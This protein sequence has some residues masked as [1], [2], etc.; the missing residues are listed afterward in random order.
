MFVVALLTHLAALLSDLL[1]ELA[2]K[3]SLM[4]EAWLLLG[5]CPMSNQK[6]TNSRKRKPMTLDEYALVAECCLFLPVT[7]TS[8]YP[9]RLQPAW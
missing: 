8:G 3:L 7:D 4:L 2:R 9:C 6:T 1:F 5:M